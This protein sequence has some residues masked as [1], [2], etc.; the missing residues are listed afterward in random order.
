MHRP[1]LAALALG[2]SL[3]ACGSTVQLSGTTTTDSGLGGQSTTGNGADG[4]TTGTSGGLDSS[5]ASGGRLGTSTGGSSTSSTSGASSGGA[6]ST[7]GPIGSTTGAIGSTSGTGG[8]GKKNPVEVGI[9]LFPDVAQF[10]ASLGGSSGNAGNQQ[11]MVDRM[12]GYINAHGGL[13]GHKVKSVVHNVSLTSSKSYAQIEQEV[14]TDFTQDHHVVAALTVGANVDNYLP[15]C[16]GK[17][18][19]LYLGGGHY[20]H[21]ETDFRA[22]PNMV[23]PGE[24][25]MTRLAK[26]M[27]SEMFARGV[28]KSGQKLGMLVEDHPAALRATNNILRPQLKARGVTLVDYTIKGPS[29]TPDIANSV[30]AIQSA[31]LKMATQNVAAVSFLCAGCFSF[32][33]QDAESQGYY[34]RYFLHSIDNLGAIA[35]KN[36]AQSM[37]NVIALGFDPLRDVGGFTHKSAFSPNPSRDLCHTIMKGLPTDDTSEGI[38]QILCGGYLDLLAAADKLKGAALNGDN[39]MAGFNAFGRSHFSAVNFA[40]EINASRH[41]GTY[42]YRTMHYDAGTD[43]LAYDSKALHPFAE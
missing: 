24:V 17:K 36:H 3:S 31:E 28:L 41:D 30:S 21:D 14:C 27:I 32:F 40:T 22:L 39:L 15:D 10:S 37:K 2:L 43:A 20:L 8:G 29:S 35:G 42:G 7:S 9:V 19:V 11:T 26:A 5:G 12:I 18:H 13:D 25:S 1:A 16:L 38:T 4:G 6:G 34:P 23:M 33:L